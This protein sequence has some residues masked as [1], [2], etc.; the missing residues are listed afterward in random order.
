M[1]EE[2]AARRA[3]E[4]ADRLELQ[5]IQPITPPPRR[6]TTPPETPPKKRRRRKPKRK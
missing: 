6:F 2:E 5:R 1:T 3:R 4:L